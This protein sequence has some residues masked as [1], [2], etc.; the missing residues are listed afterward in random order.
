MKK[1]RC[2]TDGCN[3]QQQYSVV[4]GDGVRGRYCEKCTNYFRFYDEKF[5]VY[6]LK[7]VKKLEV[8]EEQ[9]HA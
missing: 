7:S 1:T 8:K 6:G 9:H 5:N 2:I 3:E 4:F